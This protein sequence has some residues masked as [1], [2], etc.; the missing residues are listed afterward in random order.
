MIYLKF[1]EIHDGVFAKLE[2]SFL[3]F[4][5]ILHL[6]FHFKYIWKNSF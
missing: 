2:H 1:K 4:C 5:P 6:L 3:L